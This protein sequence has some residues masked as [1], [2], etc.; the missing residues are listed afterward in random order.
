M[1]YNRFFFC[2]CII[3]LMIFQFPDIAEAANSKSGKKIKNIEQLWSIRIADSFVNSHPG[4]VTYDTIMP[5]KKWNYEQGLMLEALHQMFLYTGD[6]KYYK[7]IKEN[8]D[9]YITDK[10]EIPTYSID[11][12]N[13]DLINPGRQLLFLYEV[14]GLEKYKVAADLLKKQLNNQPKTQS[15]GYWHKKI[16]PHQMWLDGLYMAE[17]FAAQYA[18]MFKDSAG[19]DNITKQFILIEEYTRDP[20][21]G[22]LYHGWDE[23]KKEKW[24]NPVTGCSPSFWGRSIGWYMMAIVDVLDFLPE[25]HQDRRKLIDIL[26]RESNALIT[27]L[28]KKT[29]LWYQ[30]ID[31]GNRKGNYLET[32][33]SAMFA[34]AFAKGSN[35]GY[36]DEQYI[37]YAKK[38]FNG[39]IKERVKINKQNFVELYGVC[40]AAGLG[41]KPYRD[42]SYEYYISEFPRMN[43]QKGYGPLILAAIEIEK[44]DKKPGSGKVIGLDNF[45][46]NEFRK[47]KAGREEQYHYIWTDTTN[48]GYSEFGKIFKENSAKLTTIKKPASYDALKN[49]DV[50]IIV[51]PDTPQETIKPN[52]FDS[53]SISSIIN[54]VKKGGILMLFSNDKGNCEFA[55][56]NQLAESFGF[57]FNE[58]SLNR[59]EGKKYEMGQFT[60]LPYHPVFFNINKIYMKEISTITVNEPQNKILSKENNGVVVFKRF[61]QGGVLAIGDPWLYNEYIDNR[62]LTRDFKNYTAAQ[63]LVTW[64]LNLSKIIR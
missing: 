61:G 18:K 37:K 42:G 1:N 23:S 19:F 10:G 26:R 59:V 53:T 63:N 54:W 24:A 4:S 22:L 30:V 27:Y 36:L 7:F 52:F 64:I 20:K 58:V 49:I 57:H 13:L 38:V 62:R 60:D 44:S 12:Y 21:T 35:R 3:I 9:Q 32:S 31:Q 48:S 56:F 34:Y 41:N 11:E 40:K 5:N 33:A 2:G 47:N 50:Y 16:Y 29:H 15:G 45:Y 43:D 14:T 6:D 55:H 25:N 39:I 46:N 17:P 8:M 28:D 51:D